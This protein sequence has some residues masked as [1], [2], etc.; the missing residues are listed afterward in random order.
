MSSDD[1]TSYGW[2]IPFLMGIVVGLIGYWIRKSMP[3][4]AHFEAAQKNGQL[5]DSPV[6]TAIKK[7]WRQI[8][9]IA[10]VVTFW[11][12]MFYMTFIFLAEYASDLKDAHSFDQASVYTYNAINFLPLFVAILAGG[13]LAD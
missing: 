10:G 13:R 2:R 11:A 9:L 8:A 12:T 1:L 3:D 4:T 6:R 5:N 7:Y